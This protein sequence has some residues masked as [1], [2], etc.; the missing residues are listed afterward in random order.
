MHLE[1]YEE[2]WEQL[3]S[4]FVASGLEAEAE[5]WAAFWA[6]GM[7]PLVRKRVQDLRGRVTSREVHVHFEKAA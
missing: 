3:L 7:V 5:A 1:Q 6:M 2:Q 4:C